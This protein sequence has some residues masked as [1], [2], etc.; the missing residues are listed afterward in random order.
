MR[1][2]NTARATVGD[3]LSG[4][5]DRVGGET[6]TGPRLTRRG[7]A[8]TGVVAVLL[9]LGWSSGARQINAVVAP[10]L[11]ALLVGFLSVRRS[12]CVT[13]ELGSPPPGI[14]GEE[15]TLVVELEG[16]GLATVALDLPEST[17]LAGGGGTDAGATV[18][19]PERV[20]WTVSPVERG[21]HEVGPLQVRVH[22]PLGLVEGPVQER[23][24][25]EL[26]VY[27]HRYDL[28]APAAA[29]GELHTRQETVTQ[30]FDRVREYNPGD[31][32]RT[33]DWK[34][35]AKH[36]DLH[37]VEFSEHAGQEAVVIAGV[38]A[39]A[40][41]DE[42]ARTVA[43]LAAAALDAGLDVGVTV[44]AGHCE[45]D[46]G[47]AHREQLL[48]L[49]AR[50]GPSTRADGYSTAASGVSDGV[51]ILVDAGDPLIRDGSREPTVR[52]AYDSYSLGELRA[53]ETEVGG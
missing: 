48:R 45:P 19:L 24:G 29:S 7:W 17:P 10:A 15:R 52:T 40:T 49:L 8:L 32:L 4:V 31:P 51:D 33:V 50:T 36:G 28:T 5:G 46:S 21:V 1:G 41:A 25:V 34:S 44:P 27:P 30:E 16:T 37:V 26:V 2:L 22:G 42:M 6:A 47:P 39:R 14:P 12:G 3:A 11:V 18:T 35:S 9:A 20:E 13:V 53:G 43:T 38:A 23:A